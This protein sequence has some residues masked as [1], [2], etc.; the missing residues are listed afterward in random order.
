MKQS[1][2]KHELGTA[3]LYCRL[4]RD[5]NMDSESN[6]IQN[7]RKILQ[8]AAKDKGYTDTV[9]FVDD[10]ITGTTMKRPGFQKMLTAIEAGYI[11]AVFVKDLSRLGRNY[12]EVGKLTEE[13]FPLHD[14]R[15]V[16]VSDGVDSDEGEDDFTPF[17]NIMNEYYAKDIS[18]KRRIVNKMKGN[19]G[20]PL[21]PPPYGYIKNPD[22]PRFW[23]VEPEAAEVVRRIYRMALEGYGLAE[24]A[25]Q[26]AA[27]GV[28]NPTYYWRSRGTSR[29]GSK[30]TVEPTKWGHTTVKKILTLQEYCG[31]VINFK[32]Y[33]KSYKMKKRI[34]NPEENRAIFLNVHEAIIDRLTWEKVQ[35]L[36][37][38]TRR[39]KPTV[40]QEPSVFS[41]L[42]KCPECGGNLNFHFNQN[43][44]D[45][46]FFSCQNHNSGYRKC[47]KTHYIRLDFLEQV[48]LYEVKRLA[49]FA[50]EY[51][52]DFIKAMIGRSAKMAENATLRKQRELDALSARDRELD[53]LFERLY[54]DNVAGKIDDARFAKMSKRYEQEQ[55]ENAKKI[56]ALRLE[57]KKDESKRMDIDDFLETVRR[58]TDAT[59]ITKR[60]VAELIDHIEVYHAEKQD[61]VTNQRVVIYYNCIGAFDVPDRRKIP[62]ADIIMETRKGVALSYAPE[63]VAV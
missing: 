32:S 10:G 35:A 39:K 19:A 11:S 34:E 8:K 18:K 52:N 25:A 9:F 3:A 43:N 15:L 63:Q 54:E 40:T 50:S 38:G 13:F 59:T 53:M 21:S 24:T 36:Q 48:V 12:I 7:Q 41:G 58:Y 28:V 61:G 2:K 30:S 55:G 29:G 31:D 49:C 16:A 62:E 33:S 60:M 26:L 5:D 14:I 6:S 56:K 20:V 46:K 1:S 4:S 45:I 44:H 57:L 47:S 17:K 51:E 22:D 37:K 42:L 27:D 23:V